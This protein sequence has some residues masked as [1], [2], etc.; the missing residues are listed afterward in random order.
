[1]FVV[2][3]GTLRLIR[4][5]TLFRK[6]ESAEK[7]P[8]L[9]GDARVH[10]DKSPESKADWRGAG[11][12]EEFSLIQEVITAARNIRSELKLDPK[13]KVSADCFVQNPL[14][15]NLIR[16]NI[17]SISSVGWPFRRSILL[18]VALIPKVCNSINCNI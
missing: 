13:R 15:L 11:V 4:R 10:Q 5:I 16:A 8:Q 9:P 7:L 3:G 17:E 2:I 1:V 12:L 6:T 18:R 14:V